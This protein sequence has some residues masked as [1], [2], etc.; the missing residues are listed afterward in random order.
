MFMF[1]ISC[2]CRKSCQHL[3]RENVLFVK[4]L[5][6]MSKEHG[7]KVTVVIFLVLSACSNIDLDAA[8]NLGESGS[9]AA[10]TVFDEAAAAEAAFVRDPER[11]VLRTAI[12]QNANEPDLPSFE[13]TYKL[14]E[15]VNA[16]TRAIGALV[17]VYK[18]FSDLARYDVAEETEIAIGSL[19]SEINK[20][21]VAVAA[22]TGTPLPLLSAPI[23]E[24]ARIGSG[25]LAE[26]AQKRRVSAASKII[27]TS[28]E[29]LIIILEKESQYAISLRVENIRSS[30][31]LSEILMERGVASYDDTVK[32]ILA[33]I[34]AMPVKDIDAAMRK[35]P[36]LRSGFQALSRY[37]EKLARNDIKNAYDAL[38]T[39]MSK[40][41]AEHKKLEEGKPVDLATIEILVSRF[42]AYYSRFRQLELTP[43]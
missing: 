11:I 15:L 38:I 9:S 18:S 23:G 2:E 5:E 30:S 31:R 41:V 34:G 12:I 16:R 28:L 39:L 36:S 29:R 24:I 3:K 40:I 13:E 19:M 4:Q 8:R 14:I 27:R 6:K 42:I 10:K 43:S 7:L 37:R 25:L 33:D 35:D 1:S 26:E 21:S 22:F 32:A 17:A 20:A